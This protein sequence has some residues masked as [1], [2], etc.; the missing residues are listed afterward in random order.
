MANGPHSKVLEAMW[1]WI[2]NNTALS[3][4]LTD[5]SRAG[6]ARKFK[7]YDGTIMPAGDVMASE[8]PALTI[9]PTGSSYPITD[10]ELAGFGPSECAIGKWEVTCYGY[11]NT[12]DFDQINEFYSLFMDAIAAG[13]PTLFAVSP[14]LSGAPVGGL[15]QGNDQILE[16]YDVRLIHPG[17]LWINPGELENENSPSISFFAIGF[18]FRTRVF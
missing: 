11:M 14:S 18:S 16:A 8:C 12:L 15:L 1:W 13:L 4:F 17:G 10:I 7:V 3:D 9:E 5:P 6:T 2:D